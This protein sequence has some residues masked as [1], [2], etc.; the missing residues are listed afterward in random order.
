MS[1]NKH[2]IGALI[3]FIVEKERNIHLTRLLKFLFI[4]DKKNFLK[5]G[6]EM[7]SSNY[8]LWKMGP[9]NEFVYFDIKPEGEGYLNDYI[10]ISQEG[11][12]V[13]FTPTDQYTDSGTFSESEIEV[14]KQVLMEY[15][16]MD[17]SKI[18]DELHRPGSLWY[19]TS[20]ETGYLE[21][22]DN[23]DVSTTDIVLDFKKLLDKDDKR[24]MMNSIINENLMFEK[25]LLSGE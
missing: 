8:L 3:A 17:T 16:A 15:S 12:N 9:V 22:F 1:I 25:A 6:I 21:R 24:L 10:T 7:T 19:L 4:I 23:S 18:I 11:T 2:R 5:T 13:R 14:I 20:K